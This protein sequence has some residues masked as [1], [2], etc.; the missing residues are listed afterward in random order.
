MVTRVEGK[1][2]KVFVASIQQGRISIPKQVREMFDTNSFIIK[3][4]EVEGERVIILK[5]LDIEKIE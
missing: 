4:S 2:K 1:D 5:P 3:V